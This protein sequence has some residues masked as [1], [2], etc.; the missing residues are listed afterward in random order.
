MQQIFIEAYNMSAIIS[1]NR[2]CK[3]EQNNQ[4]LWIHGAN[5]L[6]EREVNQPDYVSKICYTY[7]SIL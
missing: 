6:M 4:N 5:I 7:A 1:K 2:G 3:S